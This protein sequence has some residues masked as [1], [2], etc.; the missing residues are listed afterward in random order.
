[1]ARM[2]AEMLCILTGGGSEVELGKASRNQ[3]T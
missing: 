3:E 1:M 2:E